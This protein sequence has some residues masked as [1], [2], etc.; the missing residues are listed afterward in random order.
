MSKDHNE[1]KRRIIDA[2]YDSIEELIK[3]LSEKIISDDIGEDI[4]ADKMKNAVLAKKTALDDSLYILNK[5]ES[6][7]NII[8]GNNN[9]EQEEKFQS[10]AER[11]SRGKS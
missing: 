9:E 11:R 4:S 5:I 1:L 7:K 6:E 8:E 10:F 2:A 3:V